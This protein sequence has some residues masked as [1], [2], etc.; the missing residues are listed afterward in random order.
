MNYA[1]YTNSLSGFNP[2]ICQ[3]G[4]AFACMMQK[5]G[6]PRGAVSAPVM[7]R[8]THFAQA[9]AQRDKNASLLAAFR[10][11]VWYYLIKEQ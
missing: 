5:R 10:N 6:I 11:T 4:I 2:T 8:F 9:Y 1:A 7:N 3:E